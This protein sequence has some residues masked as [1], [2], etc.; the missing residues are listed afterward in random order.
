MH[1]RTTPGDAARADSSRG[2]E[3]FAPQALESDTIEFENIDFFLKPWCTVPAPRFFWGEKQ[4]GLHPQGTELFL[5]LIF[6]GIAYRVGVVMKAAIFLCDPEA[7]AFASDAMSSSSTASSSG[8]TSGGRMLAAASGPT[9]QCVGAAMGIMHGLAPFVAMFQIWSYVTTTKGKYACSSKLH[10]ILDLLSNL[11]LVFAAM[12]ISPTRGLHGSADEDADADADTLAFVIYPIIVA[13]VLWLARFAELALYSPREA[14][15]RENAQELRVG[16]VTLCLWSGAAVLAS[17]DNSRMDAQHAARADAA[18]ALLWCGNLCWAGARALSPLLPMLRPATLVPVERSLVCP[19]HGYKYERTNE[20]MFLM[21][22]EAVLQ[23]VIAAGP[24]SSAQPED[25]E[26]WVLYTRVTATAGFVLATAMMHTFQTIVKEQLEGRHE[27]NVILG[28]REAEEAQILHEIEASSQ[29]AAVRRRGSF[30]N[31]AAQKSSYAQRQQLIEQMNARQDN[32]MAVEERAQATIRIWLAL[33]FTELFLWQFNAITVLL[34]GAALKIAVSNPLEWA[35]GGYGLE[36][37]YALGG[38]VAG[39]FAIQLFYQ[40]V[41]KHW[42]DYRSLRQ[43]RR[44]PRHTCII[45]CRLLLVACSLAVCHVKLWPVAHVWMQA[46]I[47]VAQVILLHMQKH[48]FPIVPSERTRMSDE[49]A[50][51]ALRLKALRYRN[52]A[53][54]A[55]LGTAAVAADRFSRGAHASGRRSSAHGTGQRRNSFLGRRSSNNAEMGATLQARWMRNSKEDVMPSMAEMST[56]PPEAG[57]CSAPSTDEVMSTRSPVE[58]CSTRGLP[59]CNVTDL[60]ND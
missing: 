2:R 47:T 4:P 57:R 51:D 25:R 60:T 19:H 28:E 14:V 26:H 16:L 24:R 6:V 11:L 53:S 17:Q 9:Q 5:D 15:R 42:N 10:T 1:E 18:A 13:L 41:V 44:F 48:V 12:A 30:S 59:D 23:I 8:S 36:Q 58:T 43:L 39:T 22:G 35:P 52:R 32:A 37:R 50:F 29:Q 38:P 27:M 20:F 31:A 55:D 54:L 34:M 7:S 40:I 3:W 33:S 56:R 21:L 49:E 46:L 45:I